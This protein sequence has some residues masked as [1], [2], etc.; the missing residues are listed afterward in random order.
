MQTSNTINAAQ[1]QT[2]WE[3]LNAALHDI[4]N[5]APADA[6]NAIEECVRILESLGAGE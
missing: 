1:L 5:G 6:A 2:A 4:N 3:I